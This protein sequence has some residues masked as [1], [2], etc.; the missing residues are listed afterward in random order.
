MSLHYLDLFKVLQLFFVLLHS[1][2]IIR[3]VSGTN[4]FIETLISQR[5]SRQTLDSGALQVS[6][7]RRAK[8]CCAPN[9][10]TICMPVF[11]E[12]SRVGRLHTSSR[13]VRVDITMLCIPNEYRSLFSNRL[14]WDRTYGSVWHTLLREHPD[15]R[16][17][18][19]ERRPLSLIRR[20]QAPFG[21]LNIRSSRGYGSGR[22]LEL[23]DL[24]EYRMDYAIGFSQY[25]LSAAPISGRTVMRNC[26]WRSSPPP[27][28]SIPQAIPQVESSLWEDQRLSFPFPHSEP[29]VR[30]AQTGVLG[31][32]IN[33][34]FLVTPLASGV[35]PSDRLPGHTADHGQNNALDQSLFCFPS[36]RLISIFDANHTTRDRFRCICKRAEPIAI[37]KVHV[38][39]G[40]AGK[41]H[42][43]RPSPAAGLGGRKRVRESFVGWMDSWGE[44]NL[45]Y[46]RKPKPAFGKHARAETEI[47]LVGQPGGDRAKACD[48]CFFCLFPRLSILA[49]WG[50]FTF[51]LRIASRTVSGKALSF[52]AIL[53]DEHSLT[54]GVGAHEAGSE[55]FTLVVLCQG[56]IDSAV[57]NLCRELI[58]GGGGPGKRQTEPSKP[59]HVSLSIGLGNWK[60]AAIV[61]FDLSRTR[62]IDASRRRFNAYGH[63]CIGRDRT[64]SASSA[65]LAL[66]GSGEVVY[67]LKEFNSPVDENPAHQSIPA[68]ILGGTLDV[69]RTSPPHLSSWSTA[70]AP[71]HGC[72]LWHAA[73]R[74]TL[75]TTGKTLLK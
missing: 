60:F 40:R 20:A 29:S 66:S 17:D 1:C 24:R 16:A 45:N 47:P 56:S 22:Q 19:S 35:D 12:E 50:I 72:I 54:T 37:D 44:R 11:K 42:R 3:K 25:A 43:R 8:Q 13:S 14:L 59:H 31:Y 34:A 26:V 5:P 69:L 41:Y 62:E 33:V 52:L 57:V 36:L 67:Q 73:C 48:L 32:Q 55:R 30:A 61:H 71:A 68:E 28:L 27:A 9:T 70:P 21:V 51:G 64:N 58:Y 38:A 4:G 23:Q 7:G 63:V 53:P 75:P 10:V 74:N 49:R 46:L 6:R 2:I 39:H 18:C 15:Y 65:S